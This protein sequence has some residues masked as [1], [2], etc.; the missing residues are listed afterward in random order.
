MIFRKEVPLHY[1]LPENYPGKD[2]CFH[3]D[4][5]SLTENA[6]YRFN[7]NLILSDFAD[8][9]NLLKEVK[10]WPHHFDTG[11][12]IGLENNEKG[13]LIK[14]VG[15]GFAIPDSMIDEPYY[16]L[17]FWSSDGDFKPS[18]TELNFG[19]WMMPNWNGAILTISEINSALS[20][21]EQKHIVTEFFK[22][23]IKSLNAN[24]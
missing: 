12:F 4:E 21:D 22:E 24:K 11:F 1:E 3:A 17:S 14:S 18:K 2:F 15:L 16:Y 5:V 7:A 9:Y 19:K 13:E 6:N 10:I 20:A 23:G 8:Q